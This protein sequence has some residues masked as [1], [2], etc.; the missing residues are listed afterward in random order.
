MRAQPIVNGDYWFPKRRHYRVDMSIVSQIHDDIKVADMPNDVLD[1]WFAHELGHIMDYRLRSGWNLMQ[2]G[3]RYLISD[4]YRLDAERKA[5]QFAVRYG[6]GEELIATKRFI[7][8]HADVS[9][10]YKQRI[11]KYYLGPDEI[12]QLVTDHTRMQ[13]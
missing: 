3:L 13:P 12:E 8:D 10:R 5:D 11:E 4:E 2:F 9:E 1:G 6:Y 7:L